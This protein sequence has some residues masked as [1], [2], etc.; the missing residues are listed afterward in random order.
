MPENFSN[1]SLLC[2][3]VHG[4]LETKLK[5]N[6][7]HEELFVND[8]VLL[9]ETWTHDKCDLNVEG[10]EC[11]IKNRVKK[12]AA[13]RSSGGIVCYFKKSIWKGVH[14]IKWEQNEDGVVFK[15][16]KMFFGWEKDLFLLFTY[17]RPCTSSRNDV[18][19]DIDCYDMIIDKIADMED[20]ATV[21]WCGDLN[22]RISSKEGVTIVNDD[23]YRQNPTFVHEH[24]QLNTF[25]EY[26]FN[27]NNIN[28]KRT[29][30]DKKTNAYGNR[31][32]Q[33]CHTCSLVILNGRAGF[34][35]NIGKTTCWNQKGS[36]TVDY[37][38]CNKSAMYLIYN[39]SVHD[40]FIHSDH[41]IISC[42]V[43][44]NIS[45]I[46]NTDPSHNNSNRNTNVKARWR[47]ERRN[48]FEI[49]IQSDHVI[50]KVQ[51]ITDRLN[52]EL[53]D[54]GL[55]RCVYDIADIFTAAGKSHISNAHA[56]NGS[57]PSNRQTENKWYDNECTS[58]RTMFMERLKRWKETNLDAD[59]VALCKQR[60]TYRKMCRLKK[61]KLN[62]E[63]AAHIAQ[64][65]KSNPNAF[66]KEIK[67]LNNN[68]NSKNTIPDIDFFGHFKRL[69]ERD[70]DIGPEG[71]A[72]IEA[73]DMENYIK[74]TE[75]LDAPFTNDELNTAIHL[76]KSN[77]ASGPDLVLNEFISN[78]NT[79]VKALIL[80]LFN[81]I[82]K[83]EYF[84]RCWA[85]GSIV[86]IF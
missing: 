1:F 25:Y 10:Y 16:D 38:V 69:A 12:R 32:L 30:S 35:K 13:R 39:F 20:D 44:C 71:V 61:R 5:I 11:V 33:V 42:N 50:N 53:S 21:L 85:E 81:R 3:N 26:D 17:I 8:I 24:D 2:L 67:Y 43:K 82:L 80:L 45:E 9:C 40:R 48:D 31:L 59:R 19:N 84:P 52:G 34:D 64:L 62:R 54:E 55:D 73:A 46:E 14:E 27:I 76:L 63:K 51:Q 49:N 65:S 78:A 36:S 68:P 23:E 70:A 28:M 47:S 15:L 86:P 83:T 75:Y 37:L 77:K 6:D 58:L 79:H 57:L 56:P 7:F 18:I 41:Q 4:S 22:A 66:W 29:N 60:N 72:D 74:H